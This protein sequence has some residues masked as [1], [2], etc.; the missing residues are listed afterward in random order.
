MATNRKLGKPTDIR[1]AMLKTL[2]TDLIMHG[3]IETTLAQAKAASRMADKCIT[4][5]I[6]GC[7]DVISEEKKATDNKG[8]E[9]KATVVK[10]GPKKLIARRKLMAILYDKQEEKGKNEKKSAY[11]ARTEQIQ[12]P[13]IERIFDDLA[14]K[15]AKRAEELGTKGGYTRVLKTSLRRGDNAQLAIVTLV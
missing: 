15:Y 10:D 7:E 4:I 11:K 1:M 14:P 5:A 13:L 9:T 3:K 8:K 2:T 12:H 6:S